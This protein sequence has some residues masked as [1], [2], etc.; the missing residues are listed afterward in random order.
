M[1]GSRRSN[2]LNSVSGWMQCGNLAVESGDLREA[3]GDIY[4]S[5]FEDCD[6][7]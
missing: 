2:Q 5:R 1:L 7:G 6:A 3:K 4:V